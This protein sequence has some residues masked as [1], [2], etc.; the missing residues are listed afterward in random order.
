MVFL[1]HF[2]TLSHMCKLASHM[3]L[4]ARFFFGEESGIH[5]CCLFPYYMV[6]PKSRDGRLLGPRFLLYKASSSYLLHYYKCESRQNFGFLLAKGFDT[7]H[8][9]SCSDTIAFY[10]R[11]KPFTF[12]LCTNSP[13]LSVN[14]VVCIFKPCNLLLTAEH[15]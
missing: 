6:F 4:N 11:S 15:F 13:N 12:K 9:F 2:D 8:R 1:C 14:G 10:C 7:M 5:L 3:L